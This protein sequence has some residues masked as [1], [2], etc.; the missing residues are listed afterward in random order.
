MEH[1]SHI[2]DK[3]DISPVAKIVAAV[4]VLAVILAGTAYIV[5]GSGLW[6]PQVQRDSP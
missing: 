6:N 2:S 4:V 5:Y 3:P 1:Q